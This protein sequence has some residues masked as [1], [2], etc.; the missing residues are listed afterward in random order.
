MPEARGIRLNTDCYRRE[1]HRHASPPKQPRAV[2]TEALVRE[3]EAPGFV[4]NLYNVDTNK[5]V[6]VQL[7][8]VKFL[9][10]VL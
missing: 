5:K 2:L 10:R 7:I 6:N 4:P 8:N 3:L 9:L 1:H